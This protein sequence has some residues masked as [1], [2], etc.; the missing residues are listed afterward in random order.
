L[1]IK[2]STSLAIINYCEVLDQEKKFVI[3]K[4]L[5]RSATAIGAN[6]FEAQNAESELTLFTK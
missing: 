6:V 2:Q 3:A 1:S 4:Q 5:L